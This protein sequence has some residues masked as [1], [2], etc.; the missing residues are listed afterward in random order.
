MRS[1]N[2]LRFIA[3]L[4]PAIR[5]IRVQSLIL[6]GIFFLSVVNFIYFRT[7]YIFIA[8]QTKIVASLINS[9]ELYVCLNRM[10]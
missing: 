2:S 3:V 4:R 6:K 5:V 9:L 8:P 10:Q 1:L 7:L